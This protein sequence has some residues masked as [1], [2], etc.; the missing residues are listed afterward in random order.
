MQDIAA[1]INRNSSLCGLTG[2][3]NHEGIADRKLRA[4]RKN[5][6]HID[7]STAL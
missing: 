6:E 7:P 1:L 5:D 2:L 4:F 3:A